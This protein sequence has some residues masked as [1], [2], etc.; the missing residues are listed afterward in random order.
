MIEMDRRGGVGQSHL[1]DP[2][3]DYIMTQAIIR[4]QFIPCPGL[5]KEWRLRMSKAR[6]FTEQ[7]ITT[8]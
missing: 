1:S 8:S 3:L 4:S 2:I 6:G 7:R 5:G